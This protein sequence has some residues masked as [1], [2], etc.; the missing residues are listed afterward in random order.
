[1]ASKQ[2]SKPPYTFRAFW[3]LL[4]LAGNFLVAAY[5]FGVLK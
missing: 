4:L 2:T 5:Y 1:M 3:G